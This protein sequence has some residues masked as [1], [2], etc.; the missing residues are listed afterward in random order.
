MQRTETIKGKKV[1]IHAD[2]HVFVDGRDTKLKIWKSD[3]TRYS[4]LSGQEQKE[5]QGQSL[6]HAL[7]VKGFL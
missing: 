5:I 6:E 2:G 7:I 3:E 4:N 1:S